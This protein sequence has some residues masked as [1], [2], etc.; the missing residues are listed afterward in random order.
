MIIYSS[1]PCA[2]FLFKGIGTLMQIAWN[3]LLDLASVRESVLIVYLCSLFLECSGGAEWKWEVV[4][5]LAFISL[6]SQTIAIAVEVWRD[7][8]H[9]ITS[10]T[11]SWE[12][13][14][15]GSRKG[16]VY[17]W[18]HMLPVIAWKWCSVCWNI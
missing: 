5:W 13:K 14:V 16:S 8:A 6:S 1:E 18:D 2:N 9:Q 4:F 11:D 17:D 12:E 7:L 3:L 15:K 10:A